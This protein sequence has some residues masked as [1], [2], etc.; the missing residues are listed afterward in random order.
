MLS[1]NISGTWKSALAAAL[2]GAGQ[3]L[4]TGCEKQMK[5]PPAPPP[6]AVVVASA[7]SRDVPVYLDEIGKCTAVET[8]TIFPQVAGQVMN[9]HF[10]DG[11]D[12]KKD[13]DLFTINTRP[14]DAAVK[15]AK[16]TLAKDKAAAENAKAF[17]R[18]QLE[19]YNMKSISAAD[20]DTARFV[21]EAAQA[22]VD[23]DQA[24]L[25]TAQINLDFCTIKS[26]IDGRAGQRLIDA[27]NV[28]K[29]NEGAMVVIQRMDPIYADFTI[30][31]KSLA[32]VRQEMAQG[33]LKA[34]TRIPGETGDGRAGDLTF[35]DNVVK[36][37][38]GTIKLR[39]TIPN[40][41]RHFWP[42]QFVDVRLVLS[43]KKDAVLVPAAAPQLG[44][45]GTFVFVIKND[46]KGT[47]AEQRLVNLGQRQGDFVV[48]ENNLSA[49]E[50][51]ITEGQNA[52]AP[53]SP[54]TVTNPPGAAPQAAQS[55]DNSSA[56][57][58]KS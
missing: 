7:I 23:A 8:V 38:A 4:V 39:A 10:T 46:A 58:G 34:L 11:A 3:L 1:S 5:L 19:V 28:M 51:V 37:G 32:S 36:D 12:V 30:N 24:L 48:V 16:A 53:G 18:R 44:Q 25:D 52:I 57:G 40:P 42:G 17:A 35:L 13:Q 29:A 6:P 54:V 49:G 21:A 9:V 41:D 43:T 27:G 55:S 22:T 15:Q 50:T 56:N 45:T 47:L 26:P 14:F 31:E 20:Y 2:L 33:T